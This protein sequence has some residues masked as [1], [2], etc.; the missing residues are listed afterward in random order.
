MTPRARWV[1]T[2]IVFALTLVL[3][4]SDTRAHG[5]PPAALGI[6]AADEHGRPSMVLLNEG[7]AFERDDR[8]LFMCPSMWGDSDT[9][10]GKAPLARSVDG[11]ESWIIGTDD[12]YSVRDGA[13]TAQGRPDL[14]SAS[15]IALAAQDDALL[16][17]RFDA[18]GSAVVRIDDAAK[19][20][21]FTSPETWSWFATGDGN[22]HLA[23]VVADTGEVVRAVV[24]TDGEVI[25]EFR[26]PMATPLAQLRLRPTA[27]GLFAVL[28]DGQQYALV[29]IEQERWQVLLQSSGPIDG[30][31]A[32]AG[33]ALWVSLDGELM[34]DNGDGFAAVGEARRVTCL[35]QWGSHAYACVGSDLY[36][37]GDAALAEHLFQLDHLGAPDPALVPTDGKRECEFQWVLYRLDLERTGLAPRHDDDE[38]GGVSQIDDAAVAPP[39]A[40][41]GAAN[42][43]SANDSGCDCRTAPSSTDDAPPWPWFAAGL[44]L[45][46][47]TRSRRARARETR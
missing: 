29:A 17:L 15:V 27:N 16:G 11:V 42:P 38:D 24:D 14:S 12:L 31:Q 23:R 43:D 32:S 40:D 4:S 37:L 1:A 5:G 36:S 21:L 28:F 25:E 7:L 26:T 30:P 8:Y 18:D 34:S 13:L 9:S 44:A 10:A 41:S 47:L 35:E 46:R 3:P 39:P 45:W 6:V 22:L 33:G 19:A 20:A 2:L